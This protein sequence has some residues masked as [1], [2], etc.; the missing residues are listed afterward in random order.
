MLFESLYESSQPERPV[1]IAGSGRC[2]ST[3]LQSILNTNADFLI[4]GEHGGFL[5][6]VAEAYYQSHPRFPDRER[7]T[8]AERIQN[9][10][11]PRRWPAWD[12]L[13]GEEGFRERF[14][15]FV[16]S[17]FADPGGRASRWGF[18]EIRYP[19]DAEDRTLE[20]LF[21]CF[22]EASLV[23]LAREPRSTI[24]SMLSRW[25]FS[26]RKPENISTD[27]LDGGI[28]T[29][30]QSWNAQYAALH[31]FTQEHA[32]RCTAVRYEDLSSPGT[33][34]RLAS[35]LQ[36][37]SFNF[38]G[39]LLKVKDAADKTGPVAVLIER[40]MH[41]LEAQIESLTGDMRAIHGYPSL[42]TE[43][44]RRFAT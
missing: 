35:F 14:Q 4:W 13:C 34:R 24:F 22:P 17:F 6:Q 15:A 7:L 27:E 32:S 41:A 2:G 5:R 33:Y 43:P 23:V 9:L 31:R 18:K 10:R 36:A 3:L 21:E 44:Q 25:V 19:G 29:A 16:R 28:L 12:N 40:R 1:F 38:K 37:T 20:F 42:A 30:A 26:E 39:E 11:D 8:E